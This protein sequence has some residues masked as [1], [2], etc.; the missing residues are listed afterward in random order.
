MTD[1]D[2]VAVEHL[3]RRLWYAEKRLAEARLTIADTERRLEEI[4]SS[5]PWRIAARLPRASTLNAVTARVVRRGS[6]L[7]W[8]TATLQLRRR[9][10]ERQAALREAER[11]A[12]VPR[13]PA[14]Y[15]EWVK[16]YDTLEESDLE[17]MATTYERLERPPLVSVL[18]PVFDPPEPALRAAIESVRA[19]A[20]A[21]WELCIADDASSRPYVAKVL[22]E[23]EAMDE[24]VRVARRSDNGGISAAS[25]TALELARG[26]L[27]ALLDHDDVLRPHSLLLSVLAFQADSRV[28]FVYSDADRIDEHGRPLGHYFKPDWS[29]TLLLGQ[30][31]LCHL[32]VMRA[33]LLRAVGGFRSVFDGSQDWDLALRVTELLP[34]EGV[35]H[36]PH[37]LYHWRAIAGSAAA[38]GLEAKPRAA[39]AARRAVEASLQRTGRRGY[40]VPLGDH[41]K[42]RF[43]VRS[44]RPSVSIVVP[45]TGRADLLRPCVHGLLTRTAYDELEVVVAVD[46][47]AHRDPSAKTLLAEL[48]SRPR[49]RVLDYPA[50]EFNYALTVNEAVERTETP[51]VLLLNDDTEIVYD[52]WLEALVGFVQ[53]ERVGAAGG[54][55]VYPDGTIYSAG[56][57]VGSRSVAEH[58][59]HR[60]SAAVAGYAHRAQLPQEVTVVAATCMLLKREAF[61]AV[62]GLDVSFPV[63]YND[64]DLCLKLRCAGWRVIY[65]PDAVLI[66]R[67][68]ASFGTHQLGRE[69][70]HRRDTARMQ[71]RW[72][73]VLRDDPMHNPNLA[74]DASDPSQLASPPRLAYPW[75]HQRAGAEGD[76]T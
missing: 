24:R 34:P 69:A 48:A 6:K 13:P 53:E 30:N 75:R 44:P 27:V 76:G 9:L 23:Y 61:D 55:L 73:A 19:Q 28:G 49:V 60:R 22:E 11:A 2:Q 56:M 68:S 45:S 1:D 72:G 40:V 66:H 20:Y 14:A 57:L 8:W 5:T 37:V 26:E 46:E 12:K 25:N 21:N 59:Y 71:H 51:L 39:A 29:P 47:T 74:L 70:D 16:T 32:S 15:A 31:Y 33:D 36:V 62:G 18:M 42:V 58:R 43:F 65:V 50:R 38:E 10:R 17:A 4:E 64:V 41:Q 3:S 63:A 52:D 67:E 35:V 7:V 54:M